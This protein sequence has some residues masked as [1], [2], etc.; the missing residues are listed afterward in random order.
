MIEQEHFSSCHNRWPWIGG[1]FPSIL[2]NRSSVIL[3]SLALFTSICPTIEGFFLAG[4]NQISPPLTDI[5]PLLSP[6][7]SVLSPY[8]LNKQHWSNMLNWVQ[9]QCNP[10]VFFLVCRIKSEPC[11]KGEPRK[12]E[13]T[14]VGC[15][16]PGCRAPF[17]L[18]ANKV[19]E[20]FCF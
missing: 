8:D 9:H 19:R 13:L 5:L 20:A 14:P 7:T 1:M 12:L 18:H 4:F 11:P 3:L 10:T 2:L 15:S 17:R 16:I 6:S